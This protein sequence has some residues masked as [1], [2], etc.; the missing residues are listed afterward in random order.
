MDLLSEAICLL[1]DESDLG[2]MNDDARPTDAG[3]NY[4]QRPTVGHQL[5]I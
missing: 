3:C 1:S 2:G 4:S 5:G